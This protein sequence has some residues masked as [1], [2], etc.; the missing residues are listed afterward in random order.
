MEYSTYQYMRTRTYTHTHIF[1][2]I[3]WLPPCPDLECMRT[4]CAHE[5]LYN[6]HATES[7]VKTAV[8][9]SNGGPPRPATTTVPSFKQSHSL[10]LGAGSDARQHTTYTYGVTTA[11]AKFKGSPLLSQVFSTKCSPGNALHF[12]ASLETYQG[13]EQLPTW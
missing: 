11:T 7:C 8:T 5:S 13:T 6:L 3:F 12:Y 9:L 1:W 2:S 10:Q 4:S